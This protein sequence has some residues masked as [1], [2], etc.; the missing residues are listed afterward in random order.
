MHSLSRLLRGATGAGLAGVGHD[1]AVAERPSWFAAWRDAATGP[2]GFWRRSRPVD[3]LATP[4]AAGPELAEGVLELLRTWPGVTTVLDVGAG[5]GRLLEALAAAA[6]RAGRPLR[7][8]GVDLRSR[9]SDLPTAVAWAQDCW[10]VESGG[11]TTGAFERLRAGSAGPTLLLATEWLD[12]LPCRV[13]V[14]DPPGHVELDVRGR[15]AAPLAEE[16]Q[17]WVDRWWPDG[18][19]V[20]VGT[21]RDRAWAALVTS[22]RERGGL[23]LLVDYGHLRGARPAGGTL[24]GFRDGRD[25][26]AVPDRD[27]NLTAAVAVDAVA[28]VGEAAGARTCWLRRQRE[29]LTST[30]APVGQD[31]LQELAARSRRAALTDPRSWG[32]QWWLLQEVE[33]IGTAGA[34]TA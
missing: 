5:D 9:P 26:H 22:L 19:H 11:W 33:A 32:S 7:L 25:V 12:D 10:D 13:A 18:E 29:V 31:P 23:A 15:P 4:A 27:R 30:T 28:A 2:D 21:T 14:R 8:A 34:V 3:H 24:A 20:E 17:L 16:D 6:G 1:E